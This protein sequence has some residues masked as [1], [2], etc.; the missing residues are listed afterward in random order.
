VTGAVIAVNEHFMKKK[1][2]HKLC[3]NVL[4]DATKPL[5][6][7]IVEDNYDT[8]DSLA[9]CVRLFGCE[10]RVAYSPTEAGCLVRDRFEPKAILLDIGLPEMDGFALAMEICAALPKW[11]LVVAVTGHAD[12][13]GRAK[14]E[15][16][17]LHFVKPVDPS[18][19][20]DILS[21]Y[22]EGRRI[23]KWFKYRRLGASEQE[24]AQAGLSGR[25]ASS[26]P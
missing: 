10:P 6:V 9:L 14:R 24:V 18:S 5:D 1:Q 20:V 8:A 12:T 11:P 7:L 25:G 23:Q 4:M 15:G 21:T 17:D 26:I 2:Q 3:G 16:F 19:L 13:A 22:A